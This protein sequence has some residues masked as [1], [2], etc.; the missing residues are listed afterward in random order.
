MNGIDS[1]LRE[2]FRPLFFDDLGN[3]ELG[4]GKS[5][6]PRG[7]SVAV[8]VTPVMPGVSRC[9]QGIRSK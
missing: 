9:E 3:R 2:A 4:F 5:M 1:R 6:Q 7:V 8:R